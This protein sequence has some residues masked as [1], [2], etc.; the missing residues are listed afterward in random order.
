MPHVDGMQLLQTVK[1]RWP[2]VIV[3]VVTAYGSIQTAVEAMQLGAFDFLSK[4]Y[5]NQELQVK[6][7]KAVAQK[8]MVL[9]LEHMNA[10]IASYE[11]DARQQFGL[12]DMVGSSA[13]MQRVFEDVRKVAPP[14]QPC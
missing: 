10:R 5:E 13:A 7:D 2:E 4:P 1:E 14:I 12:D 9:K 3:I 8:A 11:D 6:F